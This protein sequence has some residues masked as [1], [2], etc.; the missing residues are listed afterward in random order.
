MC[1]DCEVQPR[2]DKEWK[3][4]VGMEVRVV[5]EIRSRYRKDDNGGVRRREWK[6]NDV[7]SVTCFQEGFTC[8][9]M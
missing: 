7:S 6:G 1:V 8:S 9:L 5:R 3:N 4:D 2:G